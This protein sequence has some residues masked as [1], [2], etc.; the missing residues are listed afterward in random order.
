MKTIEISEKLRNLLTQFE[1]Q[2][3]VAKLLLSDQI[4]PEFLVDNP[5]NFLS[6]SDDDGS[7]I[8][9]LTE[10]RKK[11]I[12]NEDELW[13]SK[14][15]FHCKPGAFVNKLFRNVSFFE[16]EKFST[17][18]R[19][20]SLK[21]E[22]K[23][24]VVKG[25]EIIKWYYENNYDS[26]SGSLGASCMRYANCC[27]YFDLYTDNEEASMLIMKSPSGALL[28]R[29]LIWNFNDYK[30]MD[31][32]YTV[33][34]D[35]FLAHFKSLSYDNGYIHKSRQNWQNTLQFD[36]KDQKNI[37][38]KLEIKLDNFKCDLYP[39]LDTFKWLDRNGNLTNYAPQG[40][41]FVTLSNPNGG[42]E[43]YNY[44]EFDEL[45]RDWHNSGNLIWV[46]EHKIL[47]SDRFVNYSEHLDTYILKTESKYDRKYQ[48]FLHIDDSKNNYERLEKRLEYLEK[49]KLEMSS[50]EMYLKN[51]I[52]TFEIESTQID[53]TE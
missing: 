8:S 1:D 52:N 37:E 47:T 15:R 31:I 46:E 7:K 18:F 11:V 53:T 3:Y 27:E 28:G 13:T 42:K 6:I 30:I 22:F 25:D 24:E 40:H 51:R 39:Y 43:P 35:D 26:L 45:G 17:L 50:F 4:I 5:I 38:L 44:L 21:K 19:S 2:S 36:S 14:K 12:Q 16:I 29:A 23:F 32:I 48:D 33:S 41:D 9:Y 34:D 49:S 10:E 20:Y